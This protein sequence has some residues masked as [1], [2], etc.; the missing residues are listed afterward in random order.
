MNLNSYNK[1]SA[2]GVRH[3]ALVFPSDFIGQTLS[4]TGQIIPL[5]HNWLGVNDNVQLQEWNRIY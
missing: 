4:Q 2:S 1:R 3:L 5:F